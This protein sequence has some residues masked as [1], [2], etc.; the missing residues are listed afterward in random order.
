VRQKEG[1]FLAAGV[2]LNVFPFVIF[3]PYAL[4]G[5]GLVLVVVPFVI[6]L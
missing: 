5:I 4:T 2:A 1:I 3:N 6:R